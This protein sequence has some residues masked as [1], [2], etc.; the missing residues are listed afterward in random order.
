MK[1][2]VKKKLGWEQ[3]LAVLAALIMLVSTSACSEAAARP[4]GGGQE[5]NPDQPAEGGGLAGNLADSQDLAL[6][7]YPDGTYLA[8]QDIPAGEY[9]IIVASD[10]LTY[11]AITSDTS[12]SL[13]SIIANGNFYNRS[14]VTVEPGEYLLFTQG[15]LY[16]I[17]EAPR[18]GSGTW[19]EG[20]YKIGVDLPAGE[21][22]ARSTTPIMGSLIIYPNSRHSIG[23]MTAI[24]NFNGE[25]SF[26][27]TD[28]QYLLL[29][30]AEL[31]IG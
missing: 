27:V 29:S 15:R 20:M 10:N 19:P 9:V 8:G 14:I 3:L 4:Q 6:I 30:K 31:I 24:E 12:G 7:G 16:P 13:A 1:T 21:Y 2:R 17:D 22:L 18:M 5:A 25:L 28:G 23:D 26:S 11:F